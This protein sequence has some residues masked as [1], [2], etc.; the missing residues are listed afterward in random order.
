MSTTS[1]ARPVPRAPGGGD[2]PA[3]RPRRDGRR[4][5][6]FEKKVVPYLLV[7]PYFLLFAVFGLFPIIYNGVVAFRRWHL[8]RPEEDGWYGFRN[9]TKLFSDSDFGQALVNTFGIFLLSSV[10]QLI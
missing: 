1:D 3:S 4:K 7:S 9:F 5:H 2:K 8:L 6:A 10:P